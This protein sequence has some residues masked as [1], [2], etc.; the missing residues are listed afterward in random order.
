MRR[1]ILYIFVIAL[2]LTCATFTYAQTSQSTSSKLEAPAIY[3]KAAP[4]VVLI[5]CVDS[6]GQ[7]S[8]GSGVILR[9]DGIIAT[10]H[11]VISDAV[12]A[13]IQLSNG[14]I[15]DDVSVI[16]ID[17]RKDIIVLKIKAINLPILELADSDSLKIGATVYVIGAP[18][19]L[20]GSISSGIISSLRVASEVSPDLSGFRVIQFT[21]PISHGSSGSPLIDEFGRLVG[22][23][24]ASRVDGQSINLAVPVNYIAPMVASAKNEGRRLK[25][26]SEIK[27]SESTRETSSRADNDVVGTY[28]GAWAS[29]RYGVYGMLVL[30]MSVADGQ[31]QAYV[32]LTGSEHIKED[33][34]AIKLTPMGSGIWK[35]DYKGKK[36]SVSGS[37]LFS[38]GR[39]VGDYR[40]KKLL[41]VD[42]GKWVLQ[43]N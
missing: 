27:V 23:A 29:G 3:D 7:L 39:F 10:N 36:S 16:D 42:R 1:S 15:Y 34:L 43:K 6:K 28:T 17:E 5:T 32:A 21:A 20:S 41:W 26:V 35:M 2:I 9:A 18:R 33:V 38:N 13:R 31:M 8:R 40:F 22:L 30:T 24:F 4:S 25:R 19:G 14:D 12:S 37:G 11:H